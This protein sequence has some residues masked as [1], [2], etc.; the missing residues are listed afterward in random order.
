MTLQLFRTRPTLMHHRRDLWPHGETNLFGS[1]EKAESCRRQFLASFSVP[2]MQ[3]LV[4]QWR[5][6]LCTSA[7]PRIFFRRDPLRI[8][9]SDNPSF[10]K[11]WMVRG[12]PTGLQPHYQHLAS[13]YR[14][15]LC[16][17]IKRLKPIIAV[18][19]RTMAAL[20]RQ[21]WRSSVDLVSGSL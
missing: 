15:S 6:H 14:C 18:A 21:L 5:T 12:I 20:C 4:C 1:I 17:R 11:W 9:P 19:R 8:L 7:G 16:Y 3:S 2:A 13:S 10:K